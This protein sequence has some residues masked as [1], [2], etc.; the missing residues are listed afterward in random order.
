[1]HVEKLRRIG[2][3]ANLA[4]APLDLEQALMPMRANRGFVH[5]VA[6]GALRDCAQAADGRQDAFRAAMRLHDT[7]I[8][9]NA[10][11][12]AQ[13]GEVPR[14]LADPVAAAAFPAEHLELAAVVAIQRFVSLMLGKPL[15]VARHVSAQFENEIRESMLDEPKTFLR[16]SSIELVSA[17][18]VRNELLETGD[19]IPRSCYARIVLQR[20]RRGRGV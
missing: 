9:E 1:M 4:R 20:L 14:C 15:G 11:Q 18:E 13:A 10:Q 17:R 6:C 5:R 3:G 2:G 8:G 12:S 16:A 19:P 7:R